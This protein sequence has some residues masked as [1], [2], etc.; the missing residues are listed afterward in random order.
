MTGDVCPGGRR[1]YAGAVRLLFIGDVCGKE[2]RA[3]L[4]AA[5][6]ELRERHSPDLVVANGENSA[7]GVGITPKTAQEL[8]DIGVGVI[9]TGNHVYRHRDV[10]GFLD[11]QDRIIRPANYPAA[12]PG[13]GHVIVEAGG[14]RVAVVNLSGAVM[15]KVARSPFVE[16][17]ALLSR[18]EDQ[19]DAVVV[20]FHAE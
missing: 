1:R 15:L 6:P 17:E 14:L 4:R 16:A 11:E 9:T 13:H 7:G 3:G 8:F 20:D 2:G 5:M 19:A 18:L 10:Y 12:N